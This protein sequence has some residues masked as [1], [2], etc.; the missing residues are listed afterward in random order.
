[1]RFL[2]WFLC[3][4]FCVSGCAQLAQDVSSA[5]GGQEREASDAG[6]GDSDSGLPAAG[7]D[8]GDA[9]QASGPDAPGA[10]TLPEPSAYTSA[11]DVS[12]MGDAARALLKRDLDALFAGTTHSVRVIDLDAEADIYASNPDR[13]LK[14]AS[15]TKLFTTAAAL[16]LLGP[17]HRFETRIFAS[18]PGGPAT[19][20]G[21]LLIVPEH[22]F[23]ATGD[24]YASNDVPIKRAAAAVR[25]LGLTRVLGNV[26]VRGEMV[27]GGSSVGYYDAQAHRTSGSSSW[28]AALQAEGIAVSGSMKAP[29][30]LGVPTDATLL[31]SSHSLPLYVGCSPLNVRSH[32]EYAD[33]LVRHL[34]HVI[35]GESSHAAGARS[36]LDWLVSTG[37]ETKGIAL[38]DGSGLSHDN[39]V[40]AR[41]VSDLLRFMLQTPAG[42][43]YVRSFAVAGVRGTLGSRMTGADTLGRVWGKT[44][45]LTG[46][47]ATSGLLDHRHDGHRYAFSILTNG[48]S[49]TSAMRSLHDRAVTRMAARYDELE[50]LAAPELAAAHALA[51]GL[52]R[53][54]MSVVKN[55]SAY[56]VWSSRDPE[57][58]SRAHARAYKTADVVL[59]DL[60]TDGLIYLRV[61]A[62]D[63]LGRHSRQSDTYAIR[64]SSKGPRVLL[65]DAN[66]RW[67]GRGADNPRRDPHPYLAYWAQAFAQL[68]APSPWAHARLDAME[69]GAL[70]QDEAVL[71][72]Y[73]LLVIALGEEGTDDE[74]FSTEEQALVRRW[75]DAQK[76]LVV[77]G[78]EVGYDLS[79]RGSQDDAAFFREVLHAEYVADSA[80]TF[81]LAR[82]LAIERPGEASSL[83]FFTPDRML[84]SHPDVIEAT[85]DAKPLLRYGDGRTAA[86]GFPGGA[87]LAFPLE[88]IDTIRDRADLL[89]LVL[90][91]LTV[92]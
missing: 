79:D 45:T 70:L 41:H 29:A 42:E 77:S 85:R 10:P 67:Q 39:R 74:T 78:S 31:L 8:D 47:V 11:P 87:Y 64:A 60:P 69:N 4:T 56:L 30:G 82:P 12:P 27:I 38:H 9:G 35:E 51:P 26:Q 21:D 36:V 24:F 15:N 59:G 17:E 71:E 28:R 84:I 54:R 18:K 33:I 3:S 14:P 83:S 57:T 90:T 43:D 62:V 32:N 91:D 44:G 53:V 80:G 6:G 34:G 61:S 19:V 25:A 55:A 81:Q 58:F 75:V 23:F 73:D 49:N 68:D 89:D 16:E 20:E 5:D 52:A 22:D 37:L 66:D 86:V 50:P 72:D 76:P 92:P 40:S 88:S 7:P 2:G 46:V 48:V 13:L 1:M 65:V 63:A